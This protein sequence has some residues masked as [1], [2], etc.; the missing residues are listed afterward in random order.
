MTQGDMSNI[1]NTKRLSC[2]TGLVGQRRMLPSK[3]KGG[4]SHGVLSNGC[5]WWSQIRRPCELKLPS[6]ASPPLQFRPL[7]PFNDPIDALSHPPFVP[8]SPHC[9]AL[10]QHIGN[11]ISISLCVKRGLISPGLL[12]W[13]RTKPQTGRP[14]I[15]PTSESTHSARN[16]AYFFLWHTQLSSLILTP[17]D[18]LR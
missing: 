8:L 10:H 13:W 16:L 17:V 6:P 3:G 14:Q 9:I 12:F 4:S 1:C 11:L 5:S 7:R 2:R 15:H 18:R